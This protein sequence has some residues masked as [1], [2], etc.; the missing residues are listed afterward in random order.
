MESTKGEKLAILNTVVTERLIQNPSS[1]MKKLR[2]SKLNN[3]PM[4]TQLVRGEMKSEF[5]CH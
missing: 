3:F 5:S 4:V 1:Q 2:L